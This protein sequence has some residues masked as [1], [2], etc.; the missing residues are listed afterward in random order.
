MLETQTL[1]QRLSELGILRGQASRSSDEP[2][3]WETAYSICEILRSAKD[4]EAKYVPVLMNDD[5]PENAVLALEEIR[6][7]LRHILY[8]IEDSSYFRV[9]A[10][11]PTERGMEQ[12][13]R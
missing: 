4:I 1:A 11:Q 8:H 6:E 13:P 9:I 5:V 3:E 2:I 12:T 10:G 7:E